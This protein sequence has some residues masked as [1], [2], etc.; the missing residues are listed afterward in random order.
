MEEKEKK[1]IKPSG[2]KT[3][4][5]KSGNY[6]CLIGFDT[7]DARFEIGEVISGLTGEQIES[8]IKMNAIAKEN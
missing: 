6:I 2:K 1:E 5:V 7:E 8:L 4:A 3:E